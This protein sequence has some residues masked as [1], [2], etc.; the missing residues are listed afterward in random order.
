[1]EISIR[2]N[3]PRCASLWKLQIRNI[4]LHSRVTEG[5]TTLIFSKGDSCLRWKVLKIQGRGHES[6]LY[7][8]VVEKME[9]EGTQ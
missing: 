8:V 3:G 7:I 1:M 9:W 2:E 6:K 5:W 4:H